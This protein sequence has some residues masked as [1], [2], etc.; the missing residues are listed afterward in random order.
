MSE[1][2]CKGRGFNCNLD[3]KQKD[4]CNQY[5]NN[6]IEFDKIKVQS[7]TNEIYKLEQ[8][9]ELAMIGRQEA[10]DLRDKYNLS[11][12]LLK[13][14]LLLGVSVEEIDYILNKVKNSDINID[15]NLPLEVFLTYKDLEKRVNNNLN[16]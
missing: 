2:I 11:N 1:P 12:E 9:N 6:K 4:T 10:L 14:G 15:Y 16:L 7:L 3:C 8:D 13:Q 5:V